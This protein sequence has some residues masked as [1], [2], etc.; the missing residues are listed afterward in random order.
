ML[1]GPMAM[2]GLA[3]PPPSLADLYGKEAASPLGARASP[4]ASS[5]AQT[6]GQPDTEFHGYASLYVGDLHTD[7]T[8]AMLYEIFNAAGPV[9]SIRV[10]RDSVM[11]KSLGYAYVNYRSA[12]DAEKTLDTLNDSSIMGR[13]CSILS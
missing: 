10:C 8:E 2:P 12:G 11:R 13:S 9:A 3:R 7:V 1:C 4:A 6:D 5:A